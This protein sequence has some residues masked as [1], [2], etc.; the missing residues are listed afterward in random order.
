MGEIEGPVRLTAVKQGKNTLMIKMSKGP[1][2][3]ALEMELLTLQ[4]GVAGVQWWK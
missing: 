3:G 2:S 4:D 1:G